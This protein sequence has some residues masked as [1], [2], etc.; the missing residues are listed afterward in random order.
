ME[1]PP[2]RDIGPAPRPA[3]P[4]HEQEVS[5]KRAGTSAS[6][7]FPDSS[8]FMFA[9]EPPPGENR[10]GGE[11]GTL[12]RF[13]EASRKWRVDWVDP[14]ELGGGARTWSGEVA[15]SGSPARLLAPSMYRGELA[16]GLLYADK[17]AAVVRIDAKGNAE[18]RHV[19]SEDQPLSAIAFG[20]D[21]RH[22][23]AW[24][25]MKGV[26]VNGSA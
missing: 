17:R 8:S 13:T 20:A 10:L 7:G 12:L 2:P 4:V 23:L 19:S 26:F 5:C 11:A 3:N 25:A 18:V 1:V 15:R 24:V 14:A 21:K 16:F 6:L 9:D 22:S